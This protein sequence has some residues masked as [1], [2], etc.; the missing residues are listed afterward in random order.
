[1]VGTPEGYDIPYMVNRTSRVLSKSHTRKFCLWDRMP[2]ERTLVKF[3]KDTQ[4]FELTGS[5][6]LDYLELYRK[7]TYHEMHSYHWML[8]VNMNYKN[9]K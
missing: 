9:A 4:A 2:R 5:V 7:F 8:L 3:G 1:M 6:H